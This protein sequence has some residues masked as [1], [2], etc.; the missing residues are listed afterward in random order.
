M[1][2]LLNPEPFYAVVIKLTRLKLGMTQEELALEIAMKPT[3]ISHLESGRRNLTLRTM[4]RVA[5]G[6]GVPCWQ[7][8]QLAESLEAW[9]DQSGP[10]S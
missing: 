2:P 9:V 1:S 8:M 5:G 7:M 6:L 4:K 3:E 10:S